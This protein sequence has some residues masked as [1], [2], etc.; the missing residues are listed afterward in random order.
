MKKI[1]SGLVE[2]KNT[3]LTVGEN[4]ILFKYENNTELLLSYK[5]IVFFAINE[6]EKFLIIQYGEEDTQIKFYSEDVK[7]IYDLIDKF[8]VKHPSE[9]FAN[10]L[11]GDNELYTAD[12]FK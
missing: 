1:Y 12:S 5:E 10:E 9:E 8:N 6:K 2:N 7:E 3:T 4:F 11:E